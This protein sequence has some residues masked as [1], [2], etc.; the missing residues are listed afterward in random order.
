LHWQILGSADGIA[1]TVLDERYYAEFEERGQ[2]NSYTVSVDRTCKYFRLNIL[3]VNGSTELQIAEWQLFCQRVDF[4]YPE[5]TGIKKVKTEDIK[6][7]PNPA[8]N[9]LRIANYEPH[10]DDRITIYDLF[11]RLMLQAAL[12]NTP[13]GTIDVSTLPAGTYLLEIIAQ[14]ESRTFK[15]YKKRW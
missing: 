14:Q 9:E 10:K 15:F 2:T 4:N 12:R 7:Y 5:E 1:W 3:A 13:D 8:D 6:I 11:G